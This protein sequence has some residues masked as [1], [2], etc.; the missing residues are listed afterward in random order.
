[1]ASRGP[2]DRF[3]T[4]ISPMSSFHSLFLKGGSQVGPQC[5]GSSS[6]ISRVNRVLCHGRHSV[7]IC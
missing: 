7:I 6:R 2:Q 1:M 4:E 5:P 3:G